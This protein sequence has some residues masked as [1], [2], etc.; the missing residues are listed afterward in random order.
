MTRPLHNLSGG[1]HLATH[2]DESKA[3]ESILVPLPKQIILPLKQ[4][5]GTPS[6]PVV[7]VGDRV[8]KGQI[9]AMPDGHVSVPVHA[10]TS[11]T[12]TNIGDYHIPHP[13]GIKEPCIVIEP[14]GQDELFAIEA[15][16]DYEALG[17]KEMQEIIRNCGIAGLGGA[18]FPAHVKLRE[19]V[20]NAVDTLIINGVE[21]EPFITCDD[22]LIREKAIYVVSGA[23]M[24]RHAVQARHC[25]IAVEDDMPEAFDA[26]AEQLTAFDDIELVKV[27]TCYPAGGEKQLIQ[28]LT[29]K[30]VPS[31]G[32]SIHIGIIVHNVATAAAVYRAVTRG[33]PMISRYV[34]VTGEVKAPR[35]LQVLLGTPVSDC[36]KLCD[37]EDSED[38]QIIVGGPMMGTHVKDG[39]IPVTKTTNCI[40]V[41]RK[42]PPTQDLPCI[43]CG[44]CAE[45]CPVDLLPQ[46]LYQFSKSDQFDDAKQHH[47]FDCIECG[48]C[49]Y[50]CPSHIP[51]VQYYRYAK[52]EIALE[53]QRLDGAARSE[54]R[55]LKHK[56]RLGQHQ[57]KANLH[58]PGANQ[59]TEINTDEAGKKAFVKAAVERSMKKKQ[60]KQDL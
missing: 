59:T 27:P 20:E 54:Q 10:S 47:L 17:P 39:N 52:F 3:V 30:E 35:N 6:I 34:T 46:Q 58:K 16:Q 1:L 38:N 40:I 21:C 55:F 14:D 57:E 26:L 44:R 42:N 25:V 49:S 19:G 37:Y 23:R 12:I 11:G 15:V 13:F 33:E 51:L 45:V 36:L 41:R 2:K 5:I 43:R 8:L 28:V 18:G 60:Q 29:G 24:I 53:E 22:R 56:Q 31:G 4:H 7:S 50:V 32:Y 48:C 9:I